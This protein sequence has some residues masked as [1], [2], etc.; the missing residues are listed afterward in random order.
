MEGDTAWEED[1]PFDGLIGGYV[2]ADIVLG[3]YLI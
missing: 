2:Y 1:V 3:G